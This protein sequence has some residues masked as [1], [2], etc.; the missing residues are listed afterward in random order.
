MSREDAGCNDPCGQ[1]PFGCGTCREIRGEGF[2]DE[3]G[4]EDFFETHYFSDVDMWEEEQVFQ[5]REGE[6]YD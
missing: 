5:D 3:Y 2:V 1:E 4:T 6:D